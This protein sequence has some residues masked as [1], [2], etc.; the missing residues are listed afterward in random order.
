[1]C[2]E[3]IAA[4]A[5]SGEEHLTTDPSLARMLHMHFKIYTQ[6]NLYAPSYDF[7]IM[8][9]WSLSRGAAQAVTATLVM[10]C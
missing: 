7:S 1:M 5:V 8:L 4:N 2:N 9:C 10:T 3:L 6:G